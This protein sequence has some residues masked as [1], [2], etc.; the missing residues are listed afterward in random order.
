VSS[1]Y[2][3]AGLGTTLFL[4]A[5]RNGACHSTAILPDWWLHLLEKGDWCIPPWIVQL[6]IGGRNW[7][8]HESEK[9]KKSETPR[10]YN[11]MVR[12][13]TPKDFKCCFFAIKRSRTCGSGSPQNSTCWWSRR[14]R[15]WDSLQRGNATNQ[16]IEF[17]E[18]APTV[19]KAVKR[20]L[21]ICDVDETGSH[22]L[23]NPGSS[24]AL[25]RISTK[26]ADTSSLQRV[27]VLRLVPFVS[28]QSAPDQIFY[29]T[30]TGGNL[31]QQRNS[32][33]RCW[34]SCPGRIPFNFNMSLTAVARPLVARFTAE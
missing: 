25:L 23:R 18:G 16:A 22:H 24:R 10:L 9:S 29:V 14:G 7:L 26:K 17:G 31:P 27:D 11:W 12:R 6:S 21:W 2:T 8:M 30:P 34:A 3:S 20:N 5:D 19:C 4:P 32:E 1:L 33:A 13:L 15:G 28:H